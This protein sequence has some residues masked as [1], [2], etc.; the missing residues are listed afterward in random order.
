M[1]LSTPHTLQ[2]RDACLLLVT[3]RSPTIRT[4]Y[5]TANRCIRR[6]RRV[7][8]RPISH[9]PWVS[10][11]KYVDHR[12]D[13]T[14]TPVVASCRLNSN[15]ALPDDDAILNVLVLPYSRSVYSPSPS[16][17]QLTPAH[18]LPL[19][20]PTPRR[21][22][23]SAISDSTARAVCA[24]GSHIASVALNVAPRTA[25]DATTTS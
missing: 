5:E 21:R 16:V 14:S 20:R 15:P 7:D 24:R 8:A 23:A 1:M 13:P 25:A 9:P 19:S 12:S 3:K 4:S 18:T 17:S 6:G 22:T 11:D 2:M 10:T